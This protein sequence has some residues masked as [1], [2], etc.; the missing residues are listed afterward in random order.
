VTVK[1]AM[2]E[3]ISAL[4]DGELDP[5]ERELLLRR[6]DADPDARM[7]WSRYHRIGELMRGGTVAAGD[8]LADRVRERLLDEPAHAGGSALPVWVRPLVGLAIAASVAFVAILG[9]RSQAPVTDL[10]PV[11]GAP[12]PTVV[13]GPVAVRAAALREDAEQERLRQRME[14]YLINYAEAAAA[15]QPQGLLEFV[16]VT[17]QGEL[18]QP[19]ATLAELE[20]ATDDPED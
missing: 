20:P 15:T 10:S 6:L 12:I 2:F 16:H 3:Q 11:A 8:G 17:R 18:A 14:A 9:I 7:R 5:R 1:D 13:D 4:A 19:G